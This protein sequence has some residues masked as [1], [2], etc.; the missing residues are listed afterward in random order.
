[1]APGVNPRK[2]TRTIRLSRLSTEQEPN[3]GGRVLFR[4]AGFAPALEDDSIRLGPGQLALVGFGR[5]ADPAY[6]LGIQSDIRIPRSIK[7]LQ[8]HFRHV[9]TLDGPKTTADRPQHRTRTPN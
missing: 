7:P 1:F 9:E 8:A 6:D 5:Y 2:G 4:D 3:I